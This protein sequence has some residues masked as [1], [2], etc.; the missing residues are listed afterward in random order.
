MKFWKEYIQGKLFVSF[1]CILIFIIGWFSAPI[2]ATNEWLKLTVIIISIFNLISYFFAIIVNNK[3][4]VKI[5]SNVTSFIILFCIAFPLSL[6]Y[7]NLNDLPQ[8]YSTFTVPF[9]L[10]AIVGFYEMYKNDF[11]DINKLIKTITENILYFPL[12]LAIILVVQLVTNNIKPVFELLSIERKLMVIGNI[13][14]YILLY[15]VFLSV[16]KKHRKGSTKVFSE[17]LIIIF[18]FSVYFVISF[19]MFFYKSYLD[20]DYFSF[21]IYLIRSIGLSLLGI[22]SIIFI[23]KITEYS[24]NLSNAIKIISTTYI[25]LTLLPMILNLVN[26]NKSIFLSTNS[27]F[28][29]IFTTIIATVISTLILDYLKRKSK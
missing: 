24:N 10:N 7:H 29:I 19:Y 26:Y 14:Y 2:I 3:K 6:I 13:V 18:S 21:L 22:F 11:T 17:L 8:Y 27:F 20:N 5:I 15:F 23:E 9:L 1:V 28:G 25:L 12:F 4:I 16:K